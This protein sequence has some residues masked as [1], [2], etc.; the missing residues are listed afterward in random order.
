MKQN[1]RGINKGPGVPGTLR[2]AQAAPFFSN[3]T[4]SVLDHISCER[5]NHA[6]LKTTLHGNVVKGGVKL[7]FREISG[8][9]T[10]LGAE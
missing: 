4:G 9:S 5:A 8:F 7:V 1:H 10:A 6:S 3:E 2:D